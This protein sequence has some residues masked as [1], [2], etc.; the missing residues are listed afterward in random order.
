MISC[1]SGKSSDLLFDR[2]HLFH[3]IEN[4][5]RHRDMIASESL[6]KM[7]LHGSFQCTLAQQSLMVP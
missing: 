1:H 6:L 2:D 7:R 3:L 5:A 4:K